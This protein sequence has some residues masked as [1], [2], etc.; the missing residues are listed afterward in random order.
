MTIDQAREIALALPEAFES[1]HHGHPD[2][3]IPQGIFASLWPGQDRSVLRLPPPLAEGL[4]EQ[5][6][7]TF[8]IVSRS[9]GMGW[10]SV[11]LSKVDIEEFRSLMQ[12]AC[13]ARA[14]K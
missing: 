5:A 2:F 9:G 4:A 14:R 6:P 11:T 10:V 13:E 12:T 7:E 1:A 3:R 8:R